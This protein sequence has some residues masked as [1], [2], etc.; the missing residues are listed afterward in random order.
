MNATERTHGIDL[1][2][3]PTARAHV[4]VTDLTL[5]RGYG[6]FDFLRVEEGVPLFA[7]DHLARFDRTADLLG[8]EP[9]PSGAELR[10]HVREVIAA[11]GYG[12]FGLQLFLTGGDPIDGFAP[13]TPRLVVLVV[14]LPRFRPADHEEGVALLPHRHQRDL[15]EAKTT[16]YFTAVRLYR[17][18]REAGASD[19]LYHDGARVLEST[20]CNVFVAIGE[21]RLATPGRDV[22]HGVTR[23]RML[24]LLGDDVEVRDVTLDELSAAPEVFV[25]STTRGAMPVVR[26]GDRLV[27]D[28][29]PGPIT[30]R[31]RDAFGRLRTRWLREH[32][33]AWR[34]GAAADG[35]PAL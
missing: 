3:V 15:P 16:D 5:R 22:L 10:A 27:G 7:D 21:G 14:D 13:G 11:N 4:P 31:A 30:R 12:S 23:G 17:S 28:G 34:P 20:R 29:S 2:L 8:L 6:A 1:E 18:M 26:I 35:A 33:E 19:V 32:A 9:R 24:E 25:T